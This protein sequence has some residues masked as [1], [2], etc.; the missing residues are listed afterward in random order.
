MTFDAEVRAFFAEMGAEVADNNP[1][2]PLGKAQLF[3]DG[4]GMRVTYLRAPDG[5]VQRGQ[6]GVVGVVATQTPWKVKCT[7]P[8]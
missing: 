4:T 2:N 8:S 6:R 3:H 1:Y 7:T 5:S